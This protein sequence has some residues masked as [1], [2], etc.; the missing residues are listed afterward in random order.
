MVAQAVPSGVN[1][2]T[3]DYG[4][5]THNVPYIPPLNQL[6]RSVDVSKLKNPYQNLTNLETPNATNSHNS[7]T[8]SG[9]GAISHKKKTVDNKFLQIQI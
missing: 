7:T 3:L 4:S 9:G 8:R 1:D 6:R 5:A 2:S